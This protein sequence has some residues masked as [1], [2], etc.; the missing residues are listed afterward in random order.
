MV[1][2]LSLNADMLIG[3]SIQCVFKRKYICAYT[4]TNTHTYMSVTTV[5]IKRDLEFK[6]KEKCYMAGYE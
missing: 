2:T 1:G 5:N 4:Y 6:E 3:F